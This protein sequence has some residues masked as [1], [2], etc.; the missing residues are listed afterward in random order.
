MACAEDRLLP[1][2]AN[3]SFVINISV[4]KGKIPPSPMN[5][6][7]AFGCDAQW[8]QRSTEPGCVNSKTVP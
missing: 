6:K 4:G 7:A 3:K 8:D 1:N 5:C 2:E